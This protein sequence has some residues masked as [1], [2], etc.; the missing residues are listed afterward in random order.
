M[1]RIVS[2]DYGGKRSGL[3]VSDPFKIIATGLT[4]IETPKL[5][6]LCVLRGIAGLSYWVGE[7]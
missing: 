1:G 3:A 7:V 6:G 4:T 5:I 2:I